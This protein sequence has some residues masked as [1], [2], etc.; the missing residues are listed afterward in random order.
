MIKPQLTIVC[1]VS[2]INIF[3][4]CV[5]Q[6]LYNL[7]D[8]LEFDLLPIYNSNNIYTAAITG[9]LGLDITKHRYIMYIHQD[10]QFL[11]GS[12]KQ[13]AELINSMDETRI[14]TGAV[15]MAVQY[16]ENDIDKWGFCKV[17]NKVGVV[18]NEYDEIVW[19]GIKQITPVHSLDEICI[20]IDKFSGIRFDNSVHG[21]HLY[22]LDICL[23]ARAAGYEIAAGCV[24]LRHYGK[25]SSS[26]YRDHNFINKLIQ[27]HK[28]WSM[29]VPSI[30]TPYAHW[31]NGRI[32]SYVPYA[33]KDQYDSRID[34]S[35]IAVNVI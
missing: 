15:G 20:I 11:P 22:G 17:N 26:I 31:S 21:F 28:K 16:D 33:I 1:C 5:V 3:D 32:V 6:S 18:L 25:Y 23:Q 9:N 8:F 4:E 27:L 24:N 10:I 34:V 19:D 13:I 12:G 2:N 30:Y 29:N 14:L 35:R 7:R